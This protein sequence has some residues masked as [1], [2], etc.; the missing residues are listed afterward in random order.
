MIAIEVTS[1]EDAYLKIVQS[2]SKNKAEPH[3]N[4]EKIK[5]YFESRGTPNCL[6]QTWA[7]FLRRVLVFWREPRQ[8]FMVLSPVI[9]VICMMLILTSFIKS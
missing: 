3:E 1:L 2:E 7:M 5:E 9:N 4:D 6:K 8:L